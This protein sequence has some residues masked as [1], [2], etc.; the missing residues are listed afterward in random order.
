M[1]NQSYKNISP[2]ITKL[3]NLTKQ[4]VCDL[5]KYTDTS[6]NTVSNWVNKGMTPRTETLVPI[7]QFFNVSLEYLFDDRMPD[8]VED[9][10]FLSVSEEITIT[11]TPIKPDSMTIPLKVVTNTDNGVEEMLVDDLV[12]TFSRLDKKGQ[13]AVLAEAYREQ[14]LISKNKEEK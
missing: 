5:A 12:L 8:S 1:A 10:P 6:S 4:R 9:I 2:K 3:L 13:Y 7:S 11:E 14:D